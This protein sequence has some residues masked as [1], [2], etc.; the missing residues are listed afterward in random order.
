MDGLVFLGLTVR[1][2]EI[3]TGPLLQLRK[4]W[5]VLGTIREFNRERYVGTV[6]RLTHEDKS[7]NQEAIT[8][9]NGEYSFSNVPHGHFQLFVQSTGFGNEVFSG[10]L[11]SGQAFLV[12]LI[13]LS[14][15]RHGSGHNRKGNRRPRGS[16]DRTGK[17]AGTTARIGFLSPIST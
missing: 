5:T 11:A 13:V 9:T 10:D 17:R 2:N 7:P 4:A 8:G 3:K 1:D 12:P 16:R 15:A 14:V 6:V